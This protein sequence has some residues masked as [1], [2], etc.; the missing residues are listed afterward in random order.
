MPE[1]APA[2]AAPGAAVAPPGALERYLD[3]VSAAAPPLAATLAAHGTA[4]VRDYLRVAFPVSA[5]PLQP[6]DDLC[7]AL[8]AE[9]EPLLGATVA[10]QARAALQT[11]PV[12]LTANHHG[13]DFFAQSLQGTL[14]FA[15]GE[16]GPG[17]APPVFA[18]AAVPLDN[19]TYPMGMLLYGAPGVDLDALPVKL[20][21][22]SNRYRR[23]MVGSVV[24]ID[25]G[26][27]QRAA[28]R[29]AALP[30]L[31]SALARTVATLL[32]E[33]YGAAQVTALEDYSRQSVALNQRLWQRLFR[34]PRAAPGSV[35][36]ELETLAAAM[37]K[38]DL[39]DATSLAASVHFDAPLR[40]AVF[41]A[42]DGAPACWQAE[43]LA[44]RL[45]GAGTFLYWG[46][47]ERGRRVPLYPDGAGREPVLRGR[48]DKGVE[49]E[50]ALT[51]AAILAALDDRRLVP[52]LFACF[53]V[54]A[55]ARGVTCVGAYFQARY[56]PAMKAGL[57]AALRRSGDEAAA[58]AVEAV[59]ANA[60]LAG[61][62]AL[63]WRHPQGLVPAGP[64]EIVAAGGLH[65]G[66]LEAM[67]DLPVRT[68]HA[69]G[70]LESVPDLL[71]GEQCEPGWRAAVA[72][73]L[74]ALRG[75]VVLG[76]GG[77]QGE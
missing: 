60:Y 29:C 13:V 27:R 73:E 2:L 77:D 46:I 64:A 7:E 28:A 75:L 35:T 43:R 38:R 4:A 20:P 45:S 74:Q 70:L 44:A 23:E 10:G 68:A 16:A 58:A 63:M 31:E 34:D 9:V 69:A 3:L 48:D 51:P 56:L 18:C 39:A 24:G 22:Y 26:M 32:A 17:L 30:G 21:L 11:R 12:A 57:G 1:P 37:L 42:L 25:A 53:L 54:L 76:E 40:S 71:A 15:L 52:A 62:Q 19:I 47:N 65:A 50:Y 49:H 14:L 6:R 66:A 67:L 55:L 59:P 5:R 61:M 36:V 8:Y 33:D 72:G 41:E